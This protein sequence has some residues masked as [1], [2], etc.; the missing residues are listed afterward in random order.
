MVIHYEPARLRRNSDQPTAITDV[1]VA[2][3]ASTFGTGDIP[4]GSP[5]CSARSL[6]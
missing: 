1:L 4:L 5:T 6:S 3:S 2:S